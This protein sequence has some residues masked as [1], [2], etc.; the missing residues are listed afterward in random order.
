MTN[1]SNNRCRLGWLGPCDHESRHQ[2]PPKALGEGR[3]T[4]S[5]ILFLFNGHCVSLSPN[6][7]TLNSNIQMSKA[8]KPGAFSTLP[9]KYPH[10]G[11]EIS[12]QALYCQT[13]FS[14]SARLV[15]GVK[16][17]SPSIISHANGMCTLTLQR[18]R[19]FL[20]PWLSLFQ[21]S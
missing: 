8:C 18:L 13:W 20:K 3:G 11:N 12:L 16:F 14:S 6:I 21:L 1:I 9:F 2:K 5:W 4:N 10:L 17:E 15:P 7:S 19:L